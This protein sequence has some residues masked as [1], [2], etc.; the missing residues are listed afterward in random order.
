MRQGW[1]LA[2]AH[3]KLET[4][5]AIVTKTNPLTTRAGNGHS[6]ARLGW[7]V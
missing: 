7:E 1:M 6:R 5:S 2:G 4:C 3:V